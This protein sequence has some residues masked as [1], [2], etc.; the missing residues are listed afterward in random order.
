LPP[1]PQPSPGVCAAGN[2]AHQEIDCDTVGGVFSSVGDSYAVAIAGAGGYLEIV[3]GSWII[4]SSYTVE[5]QVKVSNVGAFVTVQ[6]ISCTDN[7]GSIENKFTDFVANHH[8]ASYTATSTWQFLFTC[9]GS[10]SNNRIVSCDPEVCVRPHGDTMANRPPMTPPHPPPQPPPPPSPPALVLSSTGPCVMEGN[11]VCSS[12]YPGGTCSA[13]SAAEGS[14][15][16]NEACHVA[17]V[18]SV[19]LQVHLFDTESGYDKMTVGGIQYQGTAGPDGV[20]A[21]SLSFESDGSVQ[22]SGFKICFAPP[23]IAYWGGSDHCDSLNRCS[24]GQGDCDSDT[25]CQDGLLCFQRTY[26][27]AVPGVVTAGSNVYDVTDICYN[28]SSD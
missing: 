27:E 14:Y 24:I 12:N 28:P 4:Y 9:T 6:T 21:S 26:G 10:C 2:P 8:H 19:V 22:R 25:D 15:S 11:C 5:L 7:C 18:G 20:S 3:G 13:T 17:F 1:S 23:I 16:S